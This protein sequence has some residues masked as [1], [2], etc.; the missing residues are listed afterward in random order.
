MKRTLLVRA[1]IGIARE[2][3]HPINHRPPYT[4][5]YIQ[6]LLREEREFFVHSVDA[7]AQ[8]LS[9]NK[10]LDLTFA[11]DPN[12]L[13]ISTT[14]LDIGFA[15]SYISI[16]KQKNHGV[17]VVAVGPGPSS[18]PNLYNQNGMVDFIL[19]GESELEV[20]SI[21]KR[22]NQKENL[23]DVQRYYN[24]RLDKNKPF[25]VQDLNKLPFANYT[26]EEIIRCRMNYPL[27][28]NK[29]LYWG[30]ILSSR[31]CPYN[32]I[33]CSPLMRDS[34]GN[35]IRLRSAKNVVD[36][37]ESQLSQGVNII[38]FDDD[39]FT[40][41][42]DH[43]KSICYEILERKMRFPWIVH[44]R[45][46]ELDF[47]TIRLMKESGCVLFRFGIET[48]SEKILR[49]LGKTDDSHLWF[50]KCKEVIN[51]A[52]SLGISVV[53]LFMVGCPTETKKDLQESIRFAKTLSPDIIQVAYFVPFPGSKAY[54][55][56]RNEVKRIPISNMYHYKQPLINLSGMN[57]N[58][59]SKA[60]D[61]FYRN[62]IMSPIFM[63]RHFLNYLP[64]YLTNP[65]VFVSLFPI[66]KQTM[67]NLSRF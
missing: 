2:S 60:Q 3:Q 45:V 41:S 13:V 6:A 16:I 26:K 22:I 31:G 24:D 9:L 12:I 33:F 64:F 38:S 25:V 23:N 48:G 56:F 44:A 27:R 34:Y 61:M 11:F 18:L 17:L 63:A 53:C 39:N 20:Y 47:S 4:L 62:F 50:K 37:I 30:H 21:L 29:P 58:E 19:R 40:T 5:K 51:K 28:I 10:L 65:Y 36:E 32:C 8:S 67:R 43:V 7:Y 35:Q 1:N 52:K 15:M 66:A 46:D 57:F 49:I 55:L 14:P 59:L 42:R 54:Q